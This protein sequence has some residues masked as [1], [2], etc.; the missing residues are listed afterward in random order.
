MRVVVLFLLLAITSELSAQTADLEGREIVSLT[1]AY[2]TDGSEP[3]ESI[4]TKLRETLGQFY[5]SVRIRS[6]IQELHDTGRIAKVE[7]FAEPRGDATVSIRFVLRPIGQVR[8]V[9]IRFQPTTFTEIT[10]Q[11]LLLRTTLVQPGATV[12]DATLRNSADSIVEYLRDRGYFRAEALITREKVDPTLDE[13]VTFLVTPGTQAKV[14]AFGIDISGA[15]TKA[16]LERLRS[17][18]GADFT[19]EQLSADIER[20]RTALADQG[21]LAPRLNEPRIVYDS[22][23]NAI[24]I[25]L[26]GE[27]GASIDV[28]VVSEQSRPGRS[29][30]RRLLPIKRDGTLEYAAIIEGERRLENF[31]Q[32]QGYFFADVT[33]V[34]SVDPPIQDF[35]GTPLA[36]GTP[37]IC[38][39]LGSESLTGR[40]VSVEY[41]VDLNRRLKLVDIRLQGTDLFTIEEI[42]SVLESQRAN[43][44]GIIPLF[45][46]GRGYT[47]NR[48]LEED[49]ATIRSLL[50]ELGYRDATVRTNLGTSIDG[51]SL[52]VSFIVEEGLPT[53]IDSVQISGN[54]A[55]SDEELLAVLPDLVDKNF[56]I[57]KIRNGQRKLSEFYSSRGYFDASVTF[58]IDEIEPDAATSEP[59]FRIVYNIQNEGKPIFAD[60]I[61][62]T[63]NVRTKDSAILKALTIKPGELL[64]ATDVYTSEQNLYSSDAFERVSILP[65]SRQE[66]SDG[67]VNAD[68]IVDVSE[69]KPRLIQFGFGY[70]TDLGLS[71]SVDVR[72]FN[73]LGNLWQGGARIRW[74]ERQQ[75]AQ[76]DFINPRFIRDGQKRYAPLTFTAQYQRDATITRFFRSAFDRGTFG[77]V[78][79]VDEDG[80]PIDEF[81]VN[82]GRPTLNRLTL[83]AETN[84]TISTRDRSILF[85]RYRFEDVR[86]YNIESLLIK[87]LLRPDSKVRISGF[88]ATFVRDTRKNCSIRYTI[89]DI[90]ARG[91]AEEPCRYNA[92]DPTD[93]DYFTAEY[94]VSLPALGAN[95]GFNKFQASYRFYRRFPSFPALR[96]AVFAANAFIGVASVFS[97]SS[98]FPPDEFPGLE[99]ILPI[100][101]RFFAGG[102][103]TL[104]GFEFESAGP[105]VVIVPQ[106]QFRDRNGEPVFLSPFTV[107]FGGNAIAVVNLEARVPLTRSIR[108]VPF[109]DGG[110][111][112]RTPGDMFKTSSVPE[113]DVFRRNIRAIWSHTIGFGL[114]V[115]TPVGGE[116]GVD[117]GYLLNPPRF[118]IPQPDSSNAIF[119]PRRG[120]IHFRFSQAF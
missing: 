15:D 65:T 105:R 86:L 75:I 52:I 95:V 13:N 93:G 62:V 16:I 68:V 58:S 104:R 1:L 12:S 56:S 97:R 60:R 5:S 53:K 24:T 118:L 92:S 77:I 10:E 43:I 90:I 34:C 109:Y 91:E 19:R 115:K 88:G 33:V 20:V 64:K 35:D 51:E 102:S 17:K 72:H 73:L 96:D 81:G 26:T 116:L 39:S 85:V 25:S 46:Y 32:E 45:G 59:Q 84:R 4:R 66:R 42:S 111:V 100:S 82:T 28:E 71:G 114:R 76:I 27:A 98:G 69:Q 38:S 63:G 113:S 14:E 83:S 2:D 22:E 49:A 110:N 29:T 9:S 94:N 107:P 30:Q 70:S 7:V 117:Y 79:R 54:S 37:F 55:F 41:Q 21:F 119:Q 80:N 18:P 120:H 78:Q 50:R 47:S 89:L 8:R 44:L 67:N 108:A 6:A 61:L 101:E 87:D 106:G 3:P 74:S 23:S 57:A 103:N 36:N 11:E 99:R 31:Y 40:K 48:I 112:F